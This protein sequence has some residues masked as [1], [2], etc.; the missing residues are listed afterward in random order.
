MSKIAI[1]NTK[2]NAQF[3]ENCTEACISRLHEQGIEESEV[4][5]FTLPGA[6]E[7]PLLAKKLLTEYGYDAAI[8]IAVIYRG[9]I[10]KHE[11]VAQGVVSEIIRLNSEIGK[12]IFSSVLTPDTDHFHNPEKQAFYL[13]HLKEK[14]REVADAY[15]E[16]MEVYKSL[17]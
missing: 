16:T 13:E 6:V 8:A 11:F 15:I 9:G 2:W 7:I 1:I 5:V 14:G 17:T 3:V 12:P 10:Y 4:Q